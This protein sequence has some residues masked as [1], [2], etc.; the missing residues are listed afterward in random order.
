MQSPLQLTIYDHFSAPYSKNIDYMNLSQQ[1]Y[2]LNRV[3]LFT[4]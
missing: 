3:N 2:F 4:V 1:I